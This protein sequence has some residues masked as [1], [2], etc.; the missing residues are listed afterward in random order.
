MTHFIM[1]ITGCV[2]SPLAPRGT[3]NAISIATQRTR[4]TINAGMWINMRV[5]V[6]VAVCPCGG[7]TKL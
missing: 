6:V 3:H 7:M 2:Y 1:P 4:I 5:F